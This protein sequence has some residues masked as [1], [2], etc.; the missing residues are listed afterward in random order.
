MEDRLSIIGKAD[1]TERVLICRRSDG[2]FTYR[3][4]WA[5]LSVI[6]GQ[7]FCWGAVGP[8]L[9]IYDTPET[10]ELEAMQRVPW[11]KANFH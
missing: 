2:R 1:G 8:D 11:L 5:D 4:Q 3:R 9:G 10:A 7:D 6:T